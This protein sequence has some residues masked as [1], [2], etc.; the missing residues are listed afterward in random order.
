MPTRSQNV[1][2][3]LFDPF[4]ANLQFPMPETTKRTHLY[5]PY[6]DRII[7]PGAAATGGSICARSAGL[8]GAVLREVFINA[9][10]SPFAHTKLANVPVEWAAMDQRA[11]PTTNMELGR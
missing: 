9:C 1:G 11:I 2:F 4:T 3:T 8:D 6:T 10:S 7:H 5:E